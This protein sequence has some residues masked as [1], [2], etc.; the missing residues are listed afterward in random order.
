MKGRDDRRE[1]E[2][3][4]DEQKRGGIVR[5]TECLCRTPSGFSNFSSVCM[6]LIMLYACS[7]DADHVFM[8]FKADSGQALDALIE[9]K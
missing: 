6:F 5:R 9:N 2:E 1:E 4:S 3:R 7:K 8:F